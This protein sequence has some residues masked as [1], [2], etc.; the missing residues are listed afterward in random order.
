MSHQNECVICY[1][2]INHNQNVT[3]PNCIHGNCAHAAC[4]LSWNNTCPMCRG[5]VYDDTHT[6]DNMIHEANITNHNDDIISDDDIIITNHNDDIINNHNHNIITNYN[7]DIINNQNHNIITN[8]NH[9]INN[10]VLINTIDNNYRN[11]IRNYINSLINN[12]L[13][14]NQEYD[15]IFNTIIDLIHDNN[16][17]MINLIN[18]NHQTINNDVINSLLT[19]IYV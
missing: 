12:N 6:I 10:N 1:E 18:Y 3:F 8:Y 5:P 14:G 4:M 9:D 11:I 17:E 2:A 13:I 7:Y 19:L 15:N 16:H